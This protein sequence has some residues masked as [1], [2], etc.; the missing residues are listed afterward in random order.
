MTC[1][2]RSMRPTLTAVAGLALA[3]SMATVGP[4]RADAD[5]DS[6]LAQELTNPVADLITLPVQMNFDRELGPDDDGKKLTTNVQPVIPFHLNQE[7]NLITRTIAPVIY[8]DNVLPGSG[9]KFGLGDINASLFLSPKK[10]TGGVLWGVGPVLLLPTATDE[11]LG[12]EKWGAG[13]AAVG[14]VLRGPWTAG[15]LA[16]HVWSFAGDDDRQDV[17]NTFLQP[18]LAYTTSNAWTFSVQSETSYNWETENWSVPVNV[19]ISKLVWLGR[20]PVSLQAGA[21]YWAESPPGGPEGFRYRLQLNVV[22]P[23]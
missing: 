22:L 2:S 23:R 8:Q 16:N 4:A 13:P 11:D 17:D 14:L 12:G 15:M 19:A 20:L 7:W 10:P 5:A 18:F 21:G 3:M 9:S 1:I 6:D